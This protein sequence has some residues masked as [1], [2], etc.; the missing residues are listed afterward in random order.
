LFVELDWLHDL[1]EI[2]LFVNWA[3]IVWVLKP[4]SQRRKKGKWKKHGGGGGGGVWGRTGLGVFVCFVRLIVDGFIFFFF[5]FPSLYWKVETFGFRSFAIGRRAGGERN[6]QGKT[7]KIF[8]FSHLQSSQDPSP[9]STPL[10]QLHYPNSKNPKNFFL[11]IKNNNYYLCMSW[12]Y[13]IY[14]LIYRRRCWIG[15][16]TGV[17]IFL[18]L[19]WANEIAAF[20]GLNLFS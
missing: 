18:F 16:Y 10:F 13:N 19:F 9:P 4:V 8:G 17:K 1:H 7:P 20:D 2:V 14:L 11:K 5:F 3:P 12:S 6:K 15:L